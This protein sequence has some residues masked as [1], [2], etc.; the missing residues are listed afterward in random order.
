MASILQYE[1]LSAFDALMDQAGQRFRHD[2]TA[3]EFDALIVALTPIDPR[4]ELGED[5]R[6][7]ARLEA[8][9]D[10]LPDIVYG[11]VITQLFPTWITEDFHP[12]PK[13]RVVHREDNPAYFAIRFVM[14]K[15]ADDD[16]QP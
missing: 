13:W 15:I 3:S 12:Q 1:I 4:M 16:P 14:V 9:R 2:R 8:R 7:K 5:L 11:D 6:E 10:H